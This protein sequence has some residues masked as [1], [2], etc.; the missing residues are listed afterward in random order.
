MPASENSSIANMKASSGL[1]RDRPAKSLICST[2]WPLRRIAKM[3]ENE[4]SVIAT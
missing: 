4:P 2:A 1:V 3:I